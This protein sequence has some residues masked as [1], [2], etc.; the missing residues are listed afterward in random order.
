M[1]NRVSK[2]LIVRETAGASGS[3]LSFVEFLDGYT[4]IWT[5]E[6]TKRFMMALVTFAVCMCY[7]IL[8]DIIKKRNTG[9]VALESL[10]IGFFLLLG[11]PALWV[12]IEKTFT[13]PVTTTNE[14]AADLIVEK[15]DN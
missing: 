15:K 5:S 3:K 12:L 11:L 9:D 2:K 4:E 13:H 8:N 10:L 7:A 1:E 14:V 6:R